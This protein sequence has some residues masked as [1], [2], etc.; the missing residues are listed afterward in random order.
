MKNNAGVTHKERL[1]QFRLALDVLT[2]QR[3]A[4]STRFTLV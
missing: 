1:K 3:H 2:L 4:Y